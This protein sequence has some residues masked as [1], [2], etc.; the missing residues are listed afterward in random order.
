MK[1][2]MKPRRDMLLRTTLVYG[3]PA[4]VVPLPNGLTARWQ[5]VAKQRS[6]SILDSGFVA[7][8]Q[9]GPALKEAYRDAAVRKIE[10]YNKTRFDRPIF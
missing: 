5:Q 9:S 2:V 8:E 3:T 6:V 4:E 10:E 1:S 7:F